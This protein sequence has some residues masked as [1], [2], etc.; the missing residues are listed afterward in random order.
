MTYLNFERLNEIDPIAFQSR[1]PYPWINPEGL[2]TEDGSRGLKETLPEVSE[3]KEYFGASR[4]FGQQSHD[5]YALEYGADCRLS[6]PWQAFIAELQSPA[7]RKALERLYGA[8]GFDMWFH[9]HYTPNGCSVSPHCDSKHKLGSHL[10]YFNTEEDWDPAWGGDTLILDDGG[11]LH[12]KSGP[13][14]EDFDSAV[15]A[16]AMG[17]RSLIFQSTGNSWHGVRAVRCPEGRLR[18]VFIVVINRRTATERMRRAFGLGNGKPD[19]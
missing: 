10:F 2:L 7:Y 19:G 1:K 14:F 17:N 4:K 6:P 18:K 8:K 13:K 5:R 15:A 11:R 16:E 12:R 3:F 9:W